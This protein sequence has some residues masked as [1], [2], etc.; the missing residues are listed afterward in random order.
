M[1]KDNYFK[2][3]KGKLIPYFLG[4]SSIIV[5]IICYHIMEEDKVPTGTSRKRDMIN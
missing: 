4:K 1:G 5:A 3:M 2:W